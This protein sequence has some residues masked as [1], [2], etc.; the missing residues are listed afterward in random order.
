MDAQW[1]PFVIEIPS[2]SAWAVN[3]GAFGGILTNLS[4]PILVL[5]F[6]CLCFL[7]IKHYFYK[8]SSL[9]IQIPNKYSFE[10]GTGICIW[11][12]AVKNYGSSHCVSVVRA[13]RIASIIVFSCQTD[14]YGRFWNFL[15][16]HH[17]RHISILGTNKLKIRKRIMVVIA[18]I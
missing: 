6:P 2:F 15:F 16:Q 17:L 18:T 10:M 7:L 5:W 12:W 4:K 13:E 8:K 1:S 14:H 3:F 11:I 9:Y